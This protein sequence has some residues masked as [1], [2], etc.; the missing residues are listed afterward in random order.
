MALR[1]RFVTDERKICSPQSGRKGFLEAKL[2]LRA[3]LYRNIYRCKIEVSMAVTME[4]AVFWDIRTHF[5]PHRR[6]ITSPL[7]SPDG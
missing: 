1:I 5:V 4:N 2:Q 7:Q 3:K 6:Q